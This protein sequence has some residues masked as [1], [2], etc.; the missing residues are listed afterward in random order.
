MEAT[1]PDRMDES[2]TSAANDTA[3]FFFSEDT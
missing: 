3:D 2:R 1:S